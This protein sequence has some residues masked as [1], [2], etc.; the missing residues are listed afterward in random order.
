MGDVLHSRNLF[1]QTGI[2]VDAIVLDLLDMAI[3][4]ADRLAQRLHHRP[5]LMRMP[6][7]RILTRRTQ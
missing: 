5:E 3:E 4:R 7:C 1:A 6:P 2:R